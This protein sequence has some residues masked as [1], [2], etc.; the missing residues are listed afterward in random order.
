[1]KLSHEKAIKAHL[2]QRKNTWVSLVDLSEGTKLV[3]ESQC[4]VVH[5]RIAGL[6]KRGLNIENKTMQHGRSVHSYYRLV[7]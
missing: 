5:S 7:E 6:R 4:Y 2:E 1:M 3:C